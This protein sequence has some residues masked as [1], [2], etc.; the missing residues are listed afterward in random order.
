MSADRA[1]I[2]GHHDDLYTAAGALEQ[3]L[4]GRKFTLDC[5]LVGA[6]AW[7]VAKITQTNGQCPIGLTRLAAL[8]ATVSDA[9]RLPVIRAARI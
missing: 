3:M 2:T 9:D 7:P 8:A 6:V 5:H 4:P 1:R